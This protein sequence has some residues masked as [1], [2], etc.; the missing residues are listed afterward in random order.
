L[1]H[2]ELTLE[3]AAD[4]QQAV[5]LLANAVADV[6]IDRESAGIRRIAV[7][8]ASPIDP[9]EWLNC[10]SD[11]PRYYW[12]GRDGSFESAGTGRC[13]LIIDEFSGDH[14]ETLLR[15]KNSLSNSDG[16]AKYYGGIGFPNGF[17][18]PSNGW[19]PFGQCQFVVPRFEL[20]RNGELT[21]L[22]CN[23]RGIDDIRAIKKDLLN[24]DLSRVGANNSSALSAHSRSEL[25][26]RNG[27]NAAIEAACAAFAKGTLEKIVLA[28]ET[29]LT[30]AQTPDITSILSRLGEA[31][32]NCYRFC[33]QPT[34]QSAF[35][36][37][38][39][40]RLYLR[41][42]RN[43]KSE[44][45][46]GTRRRGIDEA[47]DTRIGR[48]LLSNEKEIREQKYVVDNIK[49]AFGSLCREWRLDQSI[50][51][52]KLARVQHLLT[53]FE[54]ILNDDIDDAE[55]L[56]CL[57]PTSAVGGY[58]AQ[59]ARQ[60]IA[61]LEPFSRGWYA[62][63]IG[64]LGRDDAEFAVGI[65]SGILIGRHMKLFSGAGI[66][67]GSTPEG[68]WKEIENKISLFLKVLNA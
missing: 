24:T 51:L 18:G 42:G 41:D 32:T 66:V 28:R 27:W 46:A 25:P 55:I 34:S 43:I 5:Q 54:G 38:S 9:L 22:V 15:I 53:Q 10:R 61:E 2:P 19:E 4:L 21:Q 6:D 44:A 30:F 12:S 64:W 40:E 20:T 63:A 14:T 45:L 29:T 36:G 37:A 16:G 68:E 48:K 62:G 39:P 50:H 23:L 1:S 3:R 8:F 67:E 26:D 35:L 31:T 65:R 13:D 58:P 33:F 17:N 11:E 57:H 52:M 49:S 47:E 59:S 60:K 7:R 56:N